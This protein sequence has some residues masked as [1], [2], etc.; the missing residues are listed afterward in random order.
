MLKR[1]EVV[2]VKI[3]VIFCSSSMFMYFLVCWRT[4]IQSALAIGIS[5]VDVHEVESVCAS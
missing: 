2:G 3:V 1:L 4:R 5:R